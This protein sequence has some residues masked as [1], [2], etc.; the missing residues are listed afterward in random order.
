MSSKFTIMAETFTQLYTHIVFAVR[1]FEP[2]IQDKH[3]PELFGFFNG[4][5]TQNGHQTVIIGGTSN[6]V[7]ILIKQNP[8]QAIS[9]L[10]RE[11]KRQS[12][13]YINHQLLKDSLFRWK[14]GYSAFSHTRSQ[15]NAVYKY[16][17]KQKEYH[18]LRDFKEEYLE[19]TDQVDEEILTET[20]FKYKYQ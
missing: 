17:E 2:F 1:N 9:D 16:I 19:L 7:H 3:E 13:F 4:I 12:S 10:V 18:R 11:V 14:D 8:A 5:I 15:V 20:I 6:H